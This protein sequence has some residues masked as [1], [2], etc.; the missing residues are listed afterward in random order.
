MNVYQYS[1]APDKVPEG[2]KYLGCYRDN[3]YGRV[4]DLKQTEKDKLTPEV[5][6]LIASRNRA[7]PPPSPLR[8]RRWHTLSIS[9][10]SKLS[11]GVA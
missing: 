4:M 6:G 7:Y 11:E 3:I 10:F 8:P 1:G 9:S 5:R 2:S